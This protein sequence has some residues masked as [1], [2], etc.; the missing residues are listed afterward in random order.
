MSRSGEGQDRPELI[1]VQNP[2]HVDDDIHK[3]VLDVFFEME[4][5]KSR[6]ITEVLDWYRDEDAGDLKK[7]ELNELVEIMTC[8]KVFEVKS[9]KI[10][11]SNQNIVM[12]EEIVKNI[13]MYKEFMK[14]TVLNAKIDPKDVMGLSIINIG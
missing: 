2:R 13:V 5:R 6:Y 12:N 7:S 4:G 8:P 14:N 3:S 1:L 9:W 10:E 11:N